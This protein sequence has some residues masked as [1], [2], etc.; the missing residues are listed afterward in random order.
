[1]VDLDALQAEL[2]S[3][4]DIV[5]NALEELVQAELAGPSS[6]AMRMAR[7]ILMAGGKRWRPVLTLLAHEA[8]GGDRAGEGGRGRARFQK[9]EG[10]GF[11]RRRRA[12]D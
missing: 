4:R 7:S 10:C 8:A 9:L 1:M 6:D 12:V 3:R 5:E 2:S 11:V